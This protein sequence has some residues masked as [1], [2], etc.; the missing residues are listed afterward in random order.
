LLKRI[1]PLVQ[2]EGK[3][4]EL[5]VKRADQGM[6]R[7]DRVASELGM[8]RTCLAKGIE[9]R[10]RRAT[11]RDQE[12][13]GVVAVH[14]DGLAEL[15]IEAETDEH[16]PVPVNLQLRALAKLSRVLDRQRVQ[17][18]VGGQL[19]NGLVGRALDVQPEGLAC[20]DELR[21]QRRRGL[22]DYLAAVI[23]PAAHGS[24]LRDSVSA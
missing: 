11:Q 4:G 18:Q 3:R 7:P 2:L 16:D 19:V 12:S 23:N 1:E 21:Y 13:R 14:F 8:D 22:P 10:A 15:L 9:G 24:R 6:Q 17:P 5:G 20:L